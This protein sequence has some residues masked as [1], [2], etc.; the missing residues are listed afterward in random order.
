MQRPELENSRCFQ[1]KLNETPS[2]A[3]YVLKE[4]QVTFAWKADPESG[5]A[6]S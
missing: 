2:M 1:V 6:S 4:T 3:N 5:S